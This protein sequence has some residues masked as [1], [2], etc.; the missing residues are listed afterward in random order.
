MLNFVQMTF[1][2]ITYTLGYEY[3]NLEKTVPMTMLKYVCV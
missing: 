3:L 1:Q 2:C